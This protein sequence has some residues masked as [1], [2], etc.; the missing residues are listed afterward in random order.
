M[1]IFTPNRHYAVLIFSSM[2]AALV[3]LAFTIIGL[4]SGVANGSTLDQLRR[5]VFKIR[6]VSRDINFTYPWKKQ[7]N[8]SASGT[9]FYIGDGRIMTNAHVIAQAS[10][11]TVQRDGDAEPQSAYVEFVAHDSDL[12]ILKTSRKDY[13][14]GV[15][16]LNFGT[17]PKLRSPVITVGFPMGGEQISITEGVVSRVGFRTYVHSGDAKHLLVQVDSAINSGN[18]GG[19]VFQGRTVVGVAFQA[20]SRAENTGYIIPTPVVTRFLRD[21][22][23]GIYHGHPKSGIEVNKWY[24]MNPNAKAFHGLGRDD[25]GVKVAHVAPWSPAKDHLARADILLEIDGQKIGVDGKIDLFGERVDFLTHYDL[26]QQGDVVKFRIGQNQEIKDISFTIG[27]S[28]THH[29]T[30]NVYAKYPKFY[31]VGGMVFTSL[32]RSYLRSWGHQWY[33]KAPLLL[34]Y[35]DFYQIYEGEANQLN[36]LVVYATRL[37]HPVNT[38]SEPF[39]HNVLTSVDSQ[40]IKGISDLAARVESGLGE[41]LTFGFWESKEK[42]VLSREGVKKVNDEINTQYGVAPD[43]WFSGNEID[44][45][46]TQTRL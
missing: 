20:F 22:D 38:F 11:I 19:P 7:A 6:V 37:P 33:K 14:E 27:Q 41:F 46:K 39:I 35:L 24:M 26:K 12:A 15:K 29:F 45:A 21:I 32:S 3:S 44:G 42:L 23:D 18:S 8:Q 36:D 34:R 40:P 28:K 13:F 1:Q 25:Q 30:G 31:V 43:R 16:A 9:G 4:Q 2:I 17:L 5:S 10:F